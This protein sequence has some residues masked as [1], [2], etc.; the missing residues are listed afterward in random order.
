MEGCFRAFIDGD[1]ANPV[2]LSSGTED[3]FNSANYFN[4]GLSVFDF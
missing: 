2:F 4:A 1:E 3:Y